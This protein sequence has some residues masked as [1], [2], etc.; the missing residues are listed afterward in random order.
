MTGK[1]FL[2][3]VY[4]VILLCIGCAIADRLLGDRHGRMGQDVPRNHEKEPAGVVLDRTSDPWTL[5]GGSRLVE[6]D[7]LMMKWAAYLRLHRHEES[8]NGRDARCWTPGPAGELG[9]D[10]LTPICV[11][12]IHR[13]TRVWVDPLNEHESRWGFARWLEYH[14]PRVGLTPTDLT[15]LRQLARRGPDGYREWKEQMRCSQ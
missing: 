4:A 14:A 9:M 12:E 10:Q 8:R 13:L 1:W 2:I 15:E 7:A 5:L 6:V 11:R 3:L